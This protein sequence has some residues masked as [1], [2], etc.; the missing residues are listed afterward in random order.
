MSLFQKVVCTLL[1]GISTAVTLQGEVVAHIN[2]SK[3]VVKGLGFEKAE[4]RWQ[5]VLNQFS[6]FAGPF[7]FQLIITSPTGKRFRSG[8]IASNDLPTSATI[9][10]KNPVKGTYL[11]F[12]KL[13]NVVNG[14]F[15]NCVTTVSNDKNDVIYRK[16]TVVT[17]NSVLA[18]KRSLLT[19]FSIPN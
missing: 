3:K 4:G 15:V 19:E 1:L 17:A 9:V 10:L 14:G 16:G 2:E 5:V 11:V 7:S 13:I 8:V 12:A 6:A 18:G